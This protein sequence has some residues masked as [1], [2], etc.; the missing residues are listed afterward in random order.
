MENLSVATNFAANMASVGFR[1]SRRAYDSINVIP[2]AVGDASPTVEGFVKL[3]RYFE[4]RRARANNQP[5]CLHS[6]YSVDRPGSIRGQQKST[7]LKRNA[8]VKSD[9]MPGPVVDRPE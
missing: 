3:L 4:A 5:E 6:C 7:D 2:G 8:Q 1:Q 9:S